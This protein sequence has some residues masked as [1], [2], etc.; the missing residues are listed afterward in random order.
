M[1][2]AI[3][4]MNIGFRISYILKKLQCLSSLLISCKTNNKVQIVYL[5]SLI[6]AKNNLNSIHQ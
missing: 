3:S 6:K 2:S 5:L 4:H 1:P